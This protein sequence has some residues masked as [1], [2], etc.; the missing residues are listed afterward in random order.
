MWPY[1]E[2]LIDLRAKAVHQHH[3]DTH[4]L[5]QRQVLRQM[6]QLARSNGLAGNAHDK[7]LVAKFVDVG[8]HRTEPGHKGEGEYGGHADRAG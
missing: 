6:L 5:D 2:L 4:A 7:G 3:F 8:R 1:L